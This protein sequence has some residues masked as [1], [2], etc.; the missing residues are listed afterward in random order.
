MRVVGD[1]R[2]ALDFDGG[3][4]DSEAGG[5]HLF[6]LAGAELRVVQAER[7]GQYHV[8]RQRRLLAAGGPQVQV[9]HRFDA[10]LAASASRTARVE[11]G[12]NGLEQDAVASRSSCHAPRRRPGG[13]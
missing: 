9:V 13:R 6:E 11:I 7:A 10:R 8:G 5:E 1:A 4:L 12:G 2:V 3:V